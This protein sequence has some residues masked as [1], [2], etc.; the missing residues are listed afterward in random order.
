MIRAT[1]FAGLAAVSFI[2]AVPSASAQTAFVLGTNRAGECYR[3]A[4]SGATDLLSLNICD[5]ALSEPTLSSK[6]RVGTLVNRGVILLRRRAPIEAERDFRAALKLAPDLPAA[7]ANLGAARLL[8]G[9]P[10]EAASLIT[11]ALAGAVTDPHEA[12]FNRALAYEQLGKVREAYD[13][14]QEA[15]RLKP[16]WAAPREELARF[17][18]TG[19]P[20]RPGA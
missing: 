3:A 4:E 20:A 10:E 14:Y 1:F 11:Q 13:D 9:H 8:A 16:D 6:D 12:H 7:I 2:C 19:A 18:V 15:L 17:T 5:S